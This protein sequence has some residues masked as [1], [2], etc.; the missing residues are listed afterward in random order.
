MSNSP[1]LHC[2][3]VLVVVCSLSLHFC[4]S[5]SV[6]ATGFSTPASTVLPLR[7]HLGHH[8]VLTLPVYQRSFRSMERTPDHD[9]VNKRQA[10]RILDLA[11]VSPP[12]SY[13]PSAAP[14]LD[15]ASPPASAPASDTPSAAPSF[16]A[17]PADSTNVPE[18]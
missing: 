9:D 10:R 17:P 13:T 16:S 4:F 12:T 15:S 3:L 8:G 11:P 6:G 18:L 2:C 7:H 14:A 1:L 5:I